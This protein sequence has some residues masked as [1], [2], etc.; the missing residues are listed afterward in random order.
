M[1]I[2]PLQAVP[3]G[4]PIELIGEEIDVVR[5]LAAVGLLAEVWPDLKIGA[6]LFPP[7]EL[8]GSLIEL[9]GPVYRDTLYAELMGGRADAPC[10]CREHGLAT[11]ETV[12]VSLRVHTVGLD[13]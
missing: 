10:D 2:R 11:A 9:A 8:V 7:G 3:A 4:L 12:D 6:V 1:R 5:S 13:E